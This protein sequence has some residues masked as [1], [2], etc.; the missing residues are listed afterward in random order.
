MKKLSRQFQEVLENIPLE[1]MQ[2]TSDIIS[3]ARKNLNVQLNQNI[4]I[5]LMD[6]I[7]FCNPKTV[8]GNSTKECIALGD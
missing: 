3:Y 4:Y 1:H 8:T 5:T 7:N 6:H 2:I